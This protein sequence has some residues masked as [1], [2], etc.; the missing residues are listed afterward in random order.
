MGTNHILDEPVMGMVSEFFWGHKHGQAQEEDTTQFI[1]VCVWPGGDG[2][3]SDVERKGFF[4][5]KP[6]EEKLCICDIK[7]LIKTM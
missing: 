5:G 4:L 6:Q 2:L 1:N 7:A 3:K